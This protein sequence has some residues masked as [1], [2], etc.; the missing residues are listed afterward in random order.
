MTNEEKRLL[1]GWDKHIRE[2]TA[3]L[4]NIKEDARQDLRVMRMYADQY[5]AVWFKRLYQKNSVVFVRL[6]L[7]LARRDQVSLDQPFVILCAGSQQLW[8]AGMGPVP[9]S[10]CSAHDWKVSIDQEIDLAHQ[11]KVAKLNGAPAFFGEEQPPATLPPLVL[12]G[13]DDDE[14]PLLAPLSM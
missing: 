11:E 13:Y 1:L 5:P 14:A 2:Q 3:F 10:L 12:P 6:L 7:Q 4:K 8:E 9:I